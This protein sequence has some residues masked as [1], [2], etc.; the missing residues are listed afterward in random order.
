MVLL[1]VAW[2][3]GVA[4]G[5]QARTFESVAADGSV[6]LIVVLFAA[7][8]AGSADAPAI[9]AW[10]PVPYMA[11]ALLALALVYMMNVGMDR[12]RPFAGAWGLW[13]VGSVLVIAAIALPTALIDLEA[14]AFIGTGIGLIGKG[15]G[16]V[17][18]AV[19]LPPL[20][21]FAWL[22]EQLLSFGM[23]GEAFTPDVP[24]TEELNELL[25]DE[26]KERPS[27]TTVLGYILRFGMVALALALAFALLWLAF[28]RLSKNDEDDVD[29]REEVGADGL[30]GGLG[31]LLASTLG[32]LRDRF[33]GGLRGGD[34]VGR[35]YM[36][37]L[38]LAEDQGLPR[39]AAAT[40]AEFAPNLDAHFASSVPSA[41]SLSYA[42]ARYGGR[43]APGDEVDR[44]TIQWR[45]V[46][47]PEPPERPDEPADERA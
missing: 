42:T 19:M 18:L 15:I 46:E 29:S 21:G 24:T 7:L 16:L 47:R 5:S 10:L 37:M 35:L 6:G 30:G 3:Y 40:P 9:V 8:F 27:W 13:V 33:S 43:P 28:Q 36:S 32:R 34:A 26:D 45:E 11:V 14:L 12:A 17:L 4:R 31:S 44:L 25:D 22:I 38:R 2:I 39:P 41:I 20:I 1:G 23:G